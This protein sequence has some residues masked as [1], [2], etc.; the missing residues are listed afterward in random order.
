VIEDTV[1]FV[2]IF[3][4]LL[5]KLMFG[6]L[7]GDVIWYFLSYIFLMLLNI[8]LLCIIIVIIIFAAYYLNKKFLEIGHVTW[9]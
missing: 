7:I 6:G 3:F 9:F 5:A 8:A 4:L 1:G 2:A